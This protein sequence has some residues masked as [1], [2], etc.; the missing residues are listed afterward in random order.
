M[1][2]DHKSKEESLTI[3][4]NKRGGQ[5]RYEDVKAPEKAEWGTALNSMQQALDLEKKI[6]STLLEIVTTAERVNDHHLT[7]YIK[8]E[9]LNK[10]INLIKEL[11][12]HVTN[13]KRV[14]SGLGEFYFDRIFSSN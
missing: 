11:G 7:D 13:L 9:H 1:H 10:N 6:N 5:L 12:D 3:Y 2:S 8:S 14:G 4:L